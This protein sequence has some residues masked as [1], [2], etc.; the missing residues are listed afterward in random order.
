MTNTK[1]KAAMNGGEAT[2]GRFELVSPNLPWAIA[3]GIDGHRPYLAT[4]Y[5]DGTTVAW[6]IDENVRC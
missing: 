4:K 1:Q 5:L 2:A 6:L 3:G